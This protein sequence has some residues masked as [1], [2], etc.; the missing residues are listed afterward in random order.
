M[1]RK[2]FVTAG[3][4]QYT[5]SLEQGA[6]PSEFEFVIEGDAT[7]HERSGRAIQGGAAI[8][9]RILNLVPEPGGLEVTQRG[10]SISV[11][12]ADRPPIESSTTN[13]AERARHRIVRAPLP[14]QVVNML[15]TVGATVRAGQ[16]MLVIEAMKM[17]N[18]I[19]A[20]HPG[21]VLSVRVSVGDVVQAG[22]VLVELGG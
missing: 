16:R 10:R 15:V 8:D 17:Q 20:E 1:R 11:Q 21:R 18:P 3:G 6:S 9:G 4:K 2:Y 19:V 12:V 22:A 5:V 14:G 13:A 7:R